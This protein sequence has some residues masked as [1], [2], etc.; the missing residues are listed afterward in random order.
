MFEW[1]PVGE[2]VPDND[3]YVLLSFENFSMPSVGRYVGNEEEGGNFYNGDNETPLSKYG[4]IVNAWAE[5]P[6]PYKEVE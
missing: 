4:V 3:R 1:I 2:R 6:E 5:L